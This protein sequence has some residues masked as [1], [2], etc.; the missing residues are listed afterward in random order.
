MLLGLEAPCFLVMRPQQA[1]YLGRRQLIG[2]H[3]TAI[4]W[5]PAVVQS[6]SLPNAEELGIA[7]ATL[8]L[9]IAALIGGTDRA[10]FGCKDAI[11]PHEHPDAGP[12]IGI[13]DS[14]E[15]EDKSISPVTVSRV[16]LYLN[17]A[18][19]AGLLIHDILLEIG[20]NLPLFVPCLIMGIILA[21]LRS[22]LFPNAEPI[23]RTPALALIS[24]IS[25]GA[26]LSMSLMALQLWTLVELGAA[27]ASILALQTAVTL[28]FVIFGS[29]SINGW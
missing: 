13:A 4:A 23:A 22:F 19:I 16:L 26:F 3:G 14:A 27:I 7:V 5:S 15:N 25:L 1:F 6:A 17:L 12:I 20:V 10:L 11:Y 29:L 24:E 21:N 28:C 9:V 8:G 18:I 2:G